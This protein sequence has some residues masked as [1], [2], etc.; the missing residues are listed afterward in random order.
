MLIAVKEGISYYKFIRR[1]ILILNDYFQWWY[2]S[3]LKQFYSWWRD[4]IQFISYYL[5]IPELFSTLFQPWKKDVVFYGNSLDAKWHAFLDNI[6]SRLV[7]FTVRLFVIIFGL[8]LELCLFI[9]GLI[10]IIIWLLVIPLSIFFI[11]L[12]F[13]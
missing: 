12:T 13:I 9:F 7:G 6:I 10:S 8:F 5:S 4:L 1:G 2:G 3:G 11:I